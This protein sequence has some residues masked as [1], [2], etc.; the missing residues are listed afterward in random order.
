MSQ[1]DQSGVVLA[2]SAL[3]G[4]ARAAERRTAIFCALC[5]RRC[6]RR[7][8]SRLSQGLGVRDVP[9]CR[10][11]RAEL[12]DWCYV[13]REVRGTA[14]LLSLGGV[15]D[16]VRE[17][18]L[19]RLLLELPGHWGHSC[20]THRGRPSIRKTGE[21]RERRRTHRFVTPRTH[22]DPQS[23]V[24]ASSA[25]ARVSAHRQRPRTPLSDSPGVA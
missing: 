17:T 10:L 24:A 12:Q 1:R 5:S 3:T 25:P 15:E 9:W 13:R 7:G 22:A 4:G 19:T 21:S 16:V 20:V 14:L 2:V 18:R 8:S 11:V 6:G 23:A